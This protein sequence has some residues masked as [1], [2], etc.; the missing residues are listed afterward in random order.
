[1]S[2]ERH[3]LPQLPR[4]LHRFLDDNGNQR[5]AEALQKL[6]DE[7]RDQNTILAVIAVALIA[8][9]GLLLY[10]AR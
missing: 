7:T 4:L 5:L 6:T 2:R 1:M 9:G 8:A 3:A 10:L